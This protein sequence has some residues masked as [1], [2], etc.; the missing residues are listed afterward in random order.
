[1]SE[2]E[3]SPYEAAVKAYLDKQVESDEALKTLYVPS[4]IT[5][6]FKWITEQAR[7]VAVNNCAMIEDLQVY[8]WA[9]DYYLEEL[10]KKA[11]EKEAVELQEKVEVQKEVE[12]PAEKPKVVQGLLFDFG[13]EE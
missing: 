6:C 2:K 9:R 11:S 12:K 8:K 7:K 1:M 10:P 4:K 13:G 3:L 5:D